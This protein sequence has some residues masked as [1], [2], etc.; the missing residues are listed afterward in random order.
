MHQRT[1]LAWRA[2]VREVIESDMTEW[3]NRAD[4][5]ASHSVFRDR[6]CDFWNACEDEV[7]S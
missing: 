7:K 1:D 3:V 5:N 2:A 6:M 4:C